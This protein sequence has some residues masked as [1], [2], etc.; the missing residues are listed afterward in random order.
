LLSALLSLAT[1]LILAAT[2]IHSSNTTVEQREEVAQSIKK[3][4]QHASLNSM[5]SII[6]SHADLVRGFSFTLEQGK[7]PGESGDM[8]QPFRK[9]Y[10]GSDVFLAMWREWLY[11]FNKDY[12]ALAEYRKGKLQ[13]YFTSLVTLLSFFNKQLKAGLID[14]ELGRGLILSTIS[15]HEHRIISLHVKFSPDREILN[16]LI[17][18]TG[19][20]ALVDSVDV[21]NALKPSVPTSTG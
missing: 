12:S 8:P 13:H 5:I 16:S 11:E 3:Q 17:K 7:R 14:D 4:E 1:V 19:L 9:A 2:Y 10:S 21:T 18:E 20:Q 6:Q 15:L